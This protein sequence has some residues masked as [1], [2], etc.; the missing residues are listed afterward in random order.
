MKYTL[1]LTTALG[2]L[3]SL[4]AAE[5]AIESTAATTTGRTFTFEVA[6][7]QDGKTGAIV[8]K[9]FPEWAPLGVAHFHDLMGEGFYKDCEFFRV[10]PD[11]VVQ[12]GI[13]AVPGQFPESEPMEDDPVITSNDQG[14]IT[15]ATA[16]PG[17]RTTQLFINLKDN[18]RLDSQGFAPIAKVISGMEYVDA[19]FPDYGGEPD[20]G[21]IE[22]FGNEY[23]HKDYP[24]LSYIA[25]VKSMEGQKE[26]GGQ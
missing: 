26:D 7:L 5:E 2:A 20:Q 24:K 11:F 10:V 21:K 4:A 16:G 17:T 9:T 12:F 1:I 18:P 3:T 14:T 22:E 23:L 15:F 25:N 13:A 19:I 6:N 8:I